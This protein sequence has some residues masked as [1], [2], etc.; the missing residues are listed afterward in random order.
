MSI[1]DFNGAEP[2][3]E[4]GGLIP[5]NTIAFVVLSIRPG[6]HGEG[7]WLK[8]SK[9]GD[10]LMLDLEFTIDGGAHDR[11]KLWAMWLVQGTTEGQKTAVSIS[12]SHIRALLEGAHNIAPGDTSDAAMA[13]RRITGWGDLDGL[14]FP[15]KIGIEKGKAKND[16]SGDFYADKNIIA[17]V[18][19]PGDRDYLNP[20]PQRVSAGTPG[21]AVAAAAVAAQAPA[22]A[23]PAWAN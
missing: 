21:P 22:A 12:H 2:A 3:R 16:G 13:A 8:N 4:A 10:S 11:R 5:A 1:M 20:G 18:L 9:T 23:R 14:K 7:N 15:V 19:T 6:G 17:K